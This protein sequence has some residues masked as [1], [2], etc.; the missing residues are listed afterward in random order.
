MLV[1]INLH[2]D[3]NPLKIL[4]AGGH[5]SLLPAGG[6]TTPIHGEEHEDDEDGDEQFDERKGMG[7]TSFGRTGAEVPQRE[8]KICWNA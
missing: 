8:R 1:G 2:R 3:E 6:I 7:P 5:T 4:L